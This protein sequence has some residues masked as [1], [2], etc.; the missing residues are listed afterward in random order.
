MID[1]RRYLTEDGKYDWQK[2]DL[3]T[4]DEQNEIMNTWDSDQWEEYTD[5]DGYWTLD[6]FNEI[7]RQINIEVCLGNGSDNIYGSKEDLGPI[8]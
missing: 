7:L 2:F 3:L 1:K 5:K 8:S 6:E 4:E